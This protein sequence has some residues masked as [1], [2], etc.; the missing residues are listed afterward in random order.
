M[1][2]RE[3]HWPPRRRSE[4]LRVAE[5]EF[6]AVVGRQPTHVEV[7]NNSGA[8]PQGT[9]LIWRESS[10]LPAGTCRLGVEEP[11]R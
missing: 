5:D 6:Q 1:I 4:W 10:A 11:K 3:Y 8:P 2:W 7:P 9:A